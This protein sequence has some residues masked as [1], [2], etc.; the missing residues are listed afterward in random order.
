MAFVKIYRGSNIKRVPDT[1][2]EDYY[3]SL[4]YR[5]LK[6]PKEERRSAEGK[7]DE[8]IDIDSIPISEMNSKQVKEYASKHKIDISEAG[9]AREAKDIIRKV[10]QERE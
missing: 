6:E 2:F 5:L 3:K 8:G 1:V 9:S 10:M 4:G 7:R